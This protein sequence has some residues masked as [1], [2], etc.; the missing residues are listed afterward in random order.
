[1]MPP[2]PSASYFAPGLVYH[3]HTLDLA[4]GDRLE[5]IHNAVP[6][7]C[8]GFAINQEADVCTSLQ[9]PHSHLISTETWGTFFR[10]PFATPPLGQ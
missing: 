1:M 2:V 8:G 10:H 4:G 6:E 7:Y 9:F 5:D 3:F